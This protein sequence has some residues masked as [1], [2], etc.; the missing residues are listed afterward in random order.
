M[1]SAKIP[2][3]KLPSNFRALDTDQLFEIKL[4]MEI[5]AA[6]ID[7]QLTEAKDKARTSGTY[8]NIIGWVLRAKA[9]RAA[10][11][12]DMRQIQNEIAERKKSPEPPPP[13]TA[14]PPAQVDRSLEAIFVEIAKRR[15]TPSLF[16]DL[17]QEARE[18]QRTYAYAHL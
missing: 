17:L 16:E 14:P 2:P 7:S 15:L 10:Y 18:E 5:R 11:T 13:R 9:A 8:D 4:A 6:E 12:R 3:L 1:S